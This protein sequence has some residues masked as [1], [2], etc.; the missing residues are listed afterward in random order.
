MARP[1]AR[2][3][4]TAEA[5]GGEQVEGRRAVLELLRAGRRQVRSVSMASTVRDDSVIDE[6]RKR[7]GGTLSIVSA[8]RIDGLARSDA[9]QGVVATAA[10]L[11][12]ADLDG[13]L[14]APGAF[15][16]W[17]SGDDGGKTAALP[18]CGSLLLSTIHSPYCSS[19]S[20]LFF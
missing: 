2:S 9:P 14:G 10:P 16:L 7:A 15:G 3:R 1:P 8:E 6:I 11:R 12:V 20:F 4:A 18:T 17:G 5:L 13:L 19:C